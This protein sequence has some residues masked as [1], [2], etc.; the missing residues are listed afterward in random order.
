[1]E[2]KKQSIYLQA[3]AE[4]RLVF[5]SELQRVGTEGAKVLREL[6]NKVEKME[7][8][9]PGDILKEV[10]EAAEQLQKKIDQRSYLLVNSESWLIGRTRE[11][12]DPVNLEDVKDN[13]N[14]K[15]GS[16]SLSETVLEIRSF[17]AWAPSGD[18]FRKQSPWPS[19]LSFIADAVIREDE[20]RT[21][22]SA[23]ALSLA[24]FVSLLIEF[25]ARLQNVVDSF[26]ELSEK[27]EFRK[28]R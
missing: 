28:P 1:M 8:L 22:E 3:P 27:A 4:R 14:V 15:L 23:S 25:V 16:K 13:E 19:R 17:P 11:V 7:K 24:T 10:H 21:Y 26:Q 5:Q 20:I 12:E 18:V 9:N 2:I 6:A